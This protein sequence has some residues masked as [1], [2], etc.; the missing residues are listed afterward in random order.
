[1]RLI[2]SIFIL[3]FTSCLLAVTPAFG[4]IGLDR[5]KQPSGIVPA[6][7]N[8]AQTLGVIIKNLVTLFFSIGAVGFTIMLL[9]GTVEWILSGGDKE[10]IAGARKKITTAIIGIVLLGLSF[11]IIAVIGQ[12]TGIDILG[13]L[14]LK[15]LSIP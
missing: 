8:S 13:P 5:G 6:Q 12:I 9:W 15:N 2:L 10:K 1:M 3:L 14:P 11:A 7:G 4:Q